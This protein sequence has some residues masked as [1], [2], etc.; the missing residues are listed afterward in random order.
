M[1]WGIIIGVI[2]VVLLLLSG[3][4]YGFFRYAIDRYGV[5][6][7]DDEHMYMGEWKTYEP[8]LRAGV[9]WVKDQ[10]PEEVSIVSKDGLQLKGYLLLAKHAKRTILCVHGFRGNGIKDFGAIASFYYEQDCNLLIIDQ[11]AH[12]ASEGKYITFGIKERYDV[13]R[14][15][16]FLNER[17]GEQMPIVL[18]GVS[19]GAATVLMASGLDLPSNVQ[20]IIAD[21]GFTSPRAIYTHVAKEYYHLPAWPLIPIF[22]LLCRFVA[23]FSMDE[24]S[25]KEA[26]AKNTRP[27]L[28]V[29]GSVDRFVPTYM[30]QENYS[31]CKAEKY[32]A[33]V[34][35]AGH[36]LSY[37]V[38][39]EACQEKIK[40]F[41]DILSGTA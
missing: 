3:V 1:I 35:K 18:D 9:K 30:S 28:F 16:D 31:Y 15:I 10:N 24:M 32:I 17:L 20:G 29:H 23:G 5:K 14:W 19:M 13:R 38:E 41:F 7:P 37:L 6:E 2:V 33:I 8:T 12:G 22:G 11:R 21:C 39:M 27:I 25:T 34:P 40:A 4:E 26:L 36:G